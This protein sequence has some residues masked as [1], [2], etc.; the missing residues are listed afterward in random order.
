MS[1]NTVVRG[2][3]ARCLIRWERLSI[4]RKLISFLWYF[5]LF[6]GVLSGRKEIP[7]C[8]TPDE[9]PYRT[10]ILLIGL[11]LVSLLVY[12]VRDVANPQDIIRLPVTQPLAVA[13]PFLCLN[14][15]LQCL[16]SAMR[17]A[18]VSLRLWRGTLYGMVGYILFHW[19]WV[20][21]VSL[22]LLGT[23]PR[24][25]PFSAFGAVDGYGSAWAYGVLIVWIPL[26]S[27]VVFLVDR[28][29]MLMRSANSQV[30]RLCLV[31]AGVTMIL[32]ARMHKDTLLCPEC[33]RGIRRT[34]WGIWVPWSRNGFLPIYVSSGPIRDSD[35]TPLL[36]ANNDCVHNWMT[37]G[38]FK[39]SLAFAHKGRGWSGVP[40]MTIK[41]NNDYSQFER[42]YLLN[43]AEAKSVIQA[44]LAKG[45]YGNYLQLL[46]WLGKAYHAWRENKTH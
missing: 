41:R 12:D 27:P 16:V 39:F 6:A 13:V 26:I 33:A 1:A 30:V 5:P 28:P 14:M 10:T 36:D 3:D 17:P 34:S 11:L 8:S 42:E 20:A 15:I 40:R 35:F 4:P 29:M 23:A 19:L 37:A 31:L 7:H 32:T 45:D 38:S 18:E 43:N 46:D 22:R 21:W 44:R 2:D 9:R 24:I 25:G